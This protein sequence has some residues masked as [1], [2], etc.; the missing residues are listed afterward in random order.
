MVLDKKVKIVL[1]IAAVVIIWLLSG[2]MK[3]PEIVEKTKIDTQK[4]IPKSQDS[5]AI[6]KEKVLKVTG[7]VKAKNYIKIA[8]EVTGIVQEKLVEEGTQVKEGDLLFVVENQSLL[9]NIKSAESNLVAAELKY[10]S[11]EALF[12][13]DLASKLQLEEAT[14]LVNTAKATLASA[15]AALSH[16]EIRAPFSGTMEEIFI[17]KGEVV[18]NYP[19]GQNI[20]AKIV[21]SNDDEVIFVY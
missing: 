17:S 4:I 6:L 21:N 7:T 10:Q 12:K 15:K 19:G 18:T 20:L 11:V 13:K 5:Q 16:T 14:N 1:I 3:K 8:S 9:A 2:L